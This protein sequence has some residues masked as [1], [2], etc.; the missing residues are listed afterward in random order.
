MANV[1]QLNVRDSA[2]PTI[3]ALIESLENR[4]PLHAAMGKRAEIEYRDWFETRENEPNKKG[5]PKQHFWARIRTATAYRSADEAGAVVGIADPAL[6]QKIHGGTITP[7]EGTYLTI[8]AIAEA[9]GHSARSFDFLQFRR[10]KSGA[11][12]LVETD[13]TLLKFGRKRKDGTRNLS[14]EGRSQRGRVWYWL[15]RSVTQAADPRASP[16]EAAMQT[17]LL[18]E[19]GMFFERI[20]G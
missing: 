18:D 17:A 15:A 11:A 1:L 2:S 20:R 4:T 9:Y 13:R 14:D 5:W 10:F 7:K 12:A 3:A 16:E 6:A 8:P 19:V